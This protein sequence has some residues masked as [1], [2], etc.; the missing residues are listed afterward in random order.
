MVKS[1]LT[2]KT[3]NRTMLTD[4]YQLTMNAVYYDSKKNGTATFDLFVRKLPQDWGFLIVNGVEDAIDYATNISFDDEDIEYLRGQ[5]LFS[6]DYLGHLRGFK[7]TG[8]IRAIKEGTPVSANTPI[9]SVTAPREEA[10]LLE[11]MLLNTINFQTMVASKANRIFQAAYPAAVVD[12]GLRRA[13]DKDASMK[14]AR[15]AYI[16]GAIATSNVL[17]GK[18]YGIPV[19]GTQAHSSV[20]SFDSELEAFRAYVKTFPNKPRLLIDTYDTLQ[21]A[22]NAT[23][24]AKEMEKEGRMFG[25]VRLDSGDLAQL[26]IQ[27]RKILDDAGLG[28][29]EIDP[30]Y[31]RIFATNDLN[32]YKIKELRDRG[33]RIDG[34]GV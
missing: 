34:Y 3:E 15:A 31:A 6:E 7:F 24:V 11:T 28:H 20:M 8:E 29:V 22:R 30:K 5:E 13:Q 25:G 33:A 19:N 1:T 4:L 14:G 12:F 32:E 16:G 17:A 2:Q 23:V 26:S 9:L 10:Q 18:E 21:G 27:V